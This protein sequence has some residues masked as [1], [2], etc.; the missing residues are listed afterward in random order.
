MLGFE[1]ERPKMQRGVE[2]G[3]WQSVA[4]EG[5]R[6]LSAGFNHSMVLDSGWSERVVFW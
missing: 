2:R 1:V 5:T 6:K 4:A 3:V